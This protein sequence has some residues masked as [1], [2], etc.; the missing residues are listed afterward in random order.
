[1]ILGN[2]KGKFAIQTSY[3]IGFDSP[4]LVMASGDFNND[5]R[6][7]IVI[8]NGGSNHVDIF[9]AY[10]R[11]SFENQ[12]R[13]SAGSYPSS[14]V[15]GDFNN[16]TR[17]DIVVANLDSND[18]SVLLGN[19]NGSF[20]NQTR[21]SA[22]SYPRSVVIGNFNNDTRLDIVVANRGSND[23]S[24]LLGNGNGS[25][26]NQTRYSAG[27]YPQSVAVGDFNNDTRLD[28]V[29]ANWDSN[30]VSVLLGNGNGSFENQTRYST[31]P[32]PG[33]VVVGD[34]DN[35][36]RL[37]IVVANWDSNDVSVFLGN[38]NGSFE[39]QTR[40]SAGSYSQSVVV[41][42]FNNDARLDIVVAN[43]GS[44]DVS[45]LLGCD[46]IVFVKQIILVTGNDTRPQSLVISDFNND[47]LMD[48]GVVNSRAHNIGIFL[49]NGDIS[50]A[51][52][53]TYSTDPNL[54]PCSLAVGDFNNDTLVDM[55]FASCESD[56]VGIILGYGNGSFGHVALYSTGSNSSRYSLAV[57][58]I[59]NDTVQDIIVA[60]HDNN[61]LGALLGYGNGAFASIILFPLDYGSNP[62]AIVVGDFNNDRKLDIAVANNGTDSLNILL[63]TC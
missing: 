50:F 5:K 40:Y 42:D 48:I 61:N 57:V 44:N 19:G 36:T 34:F 37:D 21:Y 20:E 53:V 49:G 22:G 4:P 14:V 6:S 13:Y 33:S 16:D 59:N 56:S 32:N 7:E 17:L 46:N 3:E 63:Q 52:Q 55:V 18:V 23:V 35:D 58:D 60:N 54:S 8:V 47:D 11:G 9:V 27:P 62:F 15:V 2:G 45:V 38:G 1:M 26:E 39:N 30:D 29:V 12:T 10:N 24:V 51:N 41:G 31:G 43:G 25:F 28:I